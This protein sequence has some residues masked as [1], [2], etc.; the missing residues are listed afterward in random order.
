MPA[1][2]CPALA[3]H[4]ACNILAPRLWR[5]NVYAVCAVCV[6]EHAICDSYSYSYNAHKACVDI[7]LRWEEQE[8]QRVG[9]YFC[10][11]YTSVE[12]TE[13]NAQQMWLVW[14]GMQVIAT[15]YLW[16]N[17]CLLNS[18]YM[19]FYFFMRFKFISLQSCRW[20]C[21]LSHARKLPATHTDRAHNI[22]HTCGKERKRKGGREEEVRAG[23][24]AALTKKWKQLACQ[25]SFLFIVQSD[26][27]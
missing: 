8:Q 15:G 17:H 25:S 27:V 5:R 12:R 1:L 23:S 21:R 19:Y 7:L 26:C 18:A 24:K 11:P 6:C 10:I 2:P 9:S 22:C 13:G 20:R 3:T 16:V 4:Y 14:L